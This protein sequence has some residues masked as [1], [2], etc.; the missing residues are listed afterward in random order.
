MRRFGHEGVGNA[1]G[2]GIG[3]TEGLDICRY[4]SFTL[5]LLLL[6]S[7]LLHLLGLLGNRGGG[8][9]RLL[10]QLLMLLGSQSLVE[11]RL[12][13]ARGGT[14][15]HGGRGRQRFSA[16]RPSMEARLVDED[17]AEL[18]GVTWRPLSLWLARLL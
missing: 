4:L 9:Q 11:G 17:E 12:Q 18:E 16:G 7:L 1:H 2:K 10:K 8:I 6:L 3:N 5:L 14:R 15:C 13:G